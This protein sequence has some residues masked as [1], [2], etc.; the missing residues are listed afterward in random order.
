MHDFNYHFDNQYTD[1]VDHIF[2]YMRF[3][4]IS[5]EDS[6]RTDPTWIPHIRRTRFAG[7]STVQ[8][9]PFFGIV[10]S[11]GDALVCGV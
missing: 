2:H 11:L 7:I 6:R 1:I 4:A 3:M 9:P 10:P 8:T 5:D